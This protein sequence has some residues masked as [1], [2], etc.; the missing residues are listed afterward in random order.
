MM[1]LNVDLGQKGFAGPVSQSDE[2]VHYPMLHT[3]TEED[4]DLPMEGT[5]VIR[6]CVHRAVSVK[7]EDGK[8]T[9]DCDI[10]VKEIVSVNGDKKEVR[11][12]ARS[13]N[14]TESA[15]DRLAE[16]LNGHEEEEEEEEH[17]DN[18]GY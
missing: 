2:E 9:Y 5:M 6:Y 18:P 16:A 3:H 11:P 1:K 17:S 13:G 7:D 8:H 12:P 15:L 14:D 4:L 10:E